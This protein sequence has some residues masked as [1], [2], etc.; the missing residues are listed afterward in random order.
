MA[1]AL[2]GMSGDSVQRFV[3]RLLAI[4]SVCSVLDR[5]PAPLVRLSVG[6]GALHGLLQ[7]DINTSCSDVLMR[8]GCTPSLANASWFTEWP[9]EATHLLDGKE[10]K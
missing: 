6:R 4:H 5:Y 9:S 3:E 7:A 1:A 8:A 10:S 2:D